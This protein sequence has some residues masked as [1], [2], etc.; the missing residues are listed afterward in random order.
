MLTSS[1][2]CVANHPDEPSPV[3]VVVVICVKP[4]LFKDSKR[5]CIPSGYGRPQSLPTRRESSIAH[6]SSGLRGVT[7]ASESGK[8]LVGD[9]W[10]LECSPTNDYSAIPD[11]DGFVPPPN[12]QKSETISVRSFALLNHALLD[13]PER[14]L[15]AAL[16]FTKEFEIALG[17]ILC[18]QAQ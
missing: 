5:R 9:F 12:T 1:L 11:R 16:V 14:Q 7:V 6:S 4:V 2:C 18:A 15:G 17:V 8:N 3:A 13:F 10:F